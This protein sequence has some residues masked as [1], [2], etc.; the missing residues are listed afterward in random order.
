MQ[1]QE[2]IN[3]L[4]NQLNFSTKTISDIKMFHKRIA[5]S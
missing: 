4:Q 2:V 3:I 1:D 5:K